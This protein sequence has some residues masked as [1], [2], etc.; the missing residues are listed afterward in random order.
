MRNLDIFIPIDYYYYYYY[1]TYFYATLFYRPARRKVL[2][3]AYLW[4]GGIKISDL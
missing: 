4:E 1:L 2:E 3:L